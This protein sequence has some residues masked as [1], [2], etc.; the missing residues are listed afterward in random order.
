MEGP[1]SPISTTAATR[2]SRS[3]FPVLQALQAARGTTPPTATA[4]PPWGASGTALPGGGVWIRRGVVGQ[5]SQP[6]PPGHHRAAPGSLT[7]HFLFRS[8]SDTKD[9][10]AGAGPGP[11]RSPAWFTPLLLKPEEN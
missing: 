2:L 1:P 11:A 6:S 7:A 4:Q 5:Q 3:L 10:I 9:V 8:C